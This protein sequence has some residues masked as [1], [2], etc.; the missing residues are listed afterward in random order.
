MLLLVPSTDFPCEVPSEIAANAAL[1]CVQSIQ[2]S[3]NQNLRITSQNHFFAKNSQNS[4][5]IQQVS[6]QFL[7]CLRHAMG[8]Q[9]TFMTCW[10]PSQSQHKHHIMMKLQFAGLTQVQWGPVQPWTPETTKLHQ[11]LQLNTCEY[12]ILGIHHDKSEENNFAMTTKRYG[13][14]WIWWTTQLIERSWHVTCFNKHG[15]MVWEQVSEIQHK[16]PKEYDYQ[17]PFR[18][19]KNSK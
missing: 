14:L 2:Q 16:D 18:R 17:N 12:Y 5:S 3:L 6:C 11:H 4:H 19:T 13:Y 8:S 9:K 7:C 1:A 15:P 10:W